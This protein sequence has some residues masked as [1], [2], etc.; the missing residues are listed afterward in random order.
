MASGK[1][2]GLR[3]SDAMHAGLIT[4]PPETPLRT[5]ARMMSTNRVHAILVT[6]HGDEKLPRGGRWGIVESGD[7]L[8]A[9][10][11]ADVGSIS[12]A[13][14]MTSPVPVVR[15]D[16]D[17]Q[18]AVV[19]MVVHDLSHVLVVEPR[20]GRALGVVS[21]LDIARASAGF[22]ERHP[23]SGWRDETL[24]ERRART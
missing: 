2:G 18:V 4:C 5:V 10:A 15:A 22:P 21:A 7:I 19:R 13:T 20:S 23:P 3:V 14:V 11:S 8:R 9:A 17:L 16:D 6:A 12:A 1:L 24:P